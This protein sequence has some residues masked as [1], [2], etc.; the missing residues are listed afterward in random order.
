MFAE[1]D[2]LGAFMPAIAAW[3]VVSI[4]LFVIADI[5]I[6]RSGFYRLCWHTPL[7]RVALFVILF[8]GGGLALTLR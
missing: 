7:V 2:I 1:I 3:L 4:F 6:T 8:C 5:L